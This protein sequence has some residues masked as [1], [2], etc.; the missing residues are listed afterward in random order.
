MMI[1]IIGAMDEEVFYIKQKMKNVEEVVYSNII[2]YIGKLSDKDVVLV[3]SLI[4]KA[5]SSMAATILV[6][7]F[8]IDYVINIGSAGGLKSDAKISDLVI[9]SHAMFHDVDVS[10][11]GYEVG[12][13]PDLPTKFECSA[14]LL[15]IAS[16]AVSKIDLPYHIGLIISGDQ[17]I[18]DEKQLL[19]LK[20]NFNEA[21]A[22]EM[23]AA[24][25]ALVMHHYDIPFIIMRSLSDI[26]GSNSNISFEEYLDTAAKNSSNAVEKMIELI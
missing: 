5:N 4:G 22:V 10:C 12:Q 13:V 18:H 14:K 25:I 23:E 2:F 7:K 11:F 3:K 17:F 1:G 24:S 19:K 26:A 9:A 6:E 21:I 20:E 15:D 16:I 8:S